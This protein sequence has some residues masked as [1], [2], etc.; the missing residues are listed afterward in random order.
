MT[1]QCFTQALMEAP[2][3]AGIKGVQELEA[4]L[5]APVSVI[6]LLGGNICE[7][8]KM[9]QCVRAAGKKMLVHIDLLEGIGKDGY[10]V[11]YLKDTIAPDG[12]I[13]TRQSMVR[14]AMQC[15]LFVVQRIFMLDSMSLEV[16]MKA[17]KSLHPNAVEIMPGILPGI[18]GQVTHATGAP[19]IAGGLVKE[20]A[21]VIECLSAGAMGVST[22]A[23]TLW[24]M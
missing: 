21:Q 24:H 3:I 18:I 2:V 7:L 4:A 23:Q 5:E 13:T 15:G 20:K 8:E 12:I 9:V 19:I 11:Q 6:F 14:H 17:L 10:A 22:T 16:G 1:Q